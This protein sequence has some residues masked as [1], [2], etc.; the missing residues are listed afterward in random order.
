MGSEESRN[1]V[2]DRGQKGPS[3]CEAK[4]VSVGRRRGSG[5]GSE[6][7]AVPREQCTNERLTRV[8]DRPA[9]AGATTTPRPHTDSMVPIRAGSCTCPPNVFAM[10]A[11]SDVSVG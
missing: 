4:R 5:G 10:R 8:V 6:I 7:Q 11:Y 1:R 9:S 2:W 3:R